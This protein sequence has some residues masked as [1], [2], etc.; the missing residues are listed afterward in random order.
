[1]QTH[2][3]ARCFSKKY[4]KNWKTS[5]KAGWGS[6]TILVRAHKQCRVVFDD[7]IGSRAS[8]EGRRLIQRN[9]TTTTSRRS[10]SRYIPTTHWRRERERETSDDP[11]RLYYA[12]A[13]ERGFF[14]GYCPLG[15][16]V[17]YTIHFQES[18][19]NEPPPPLRSRLLVNFKKL[20]FT[21]TNFVTT[22]RLDHF[23]RTCD[24]DKSRFRFRKIRIQSGH[25]T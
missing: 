1:M 16:S 7:D 18:P 11:T 13:S 8:R 15:P 21:I 14:N 6:F 4:Y 9:G 20:F 25:E 19:S 22:S 23:G 3:I 17:F 12:R 2:W 10:I 5:K 24:T